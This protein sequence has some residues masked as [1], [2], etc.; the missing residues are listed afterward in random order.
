LSHSED[1][2]T[3]S[4]PRRARSASF[5]WRVPDS[6]PDL[7]VIETFGSGPARARTGPVRYFRSLQVP[8]GSEPTARRPR[9][10]VACAEN[11]RPGSY[12]GLSRARRR[13]KDATLMVTVMNFRNTSTRAAPSSCAA[14]L[15]ST[16]ARMYGCRHVLPCRAGHELTRDPVGDLVA[17]ATAAGDLGP[18]FALAFL[19]R[20]EDLYA[21][22]GP[23]GAD[24]RP[25]FSRLAQAWRNTSTSARR[26][27]PGIVVRATCSRQA[28]SSRRSIVS[29]A[30]TYWP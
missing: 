1:P 3:P 24:M 5:S 13:T 9:T 17:M 21:G 22:D 16:I 29:P 11:E 7:R 27:Q 23:T 20:D 6:A 18:A 12:Q 30:G 26:L 4:L 15:K 19:R 2:V 14:R 8:T 25:R 28:P 10:D